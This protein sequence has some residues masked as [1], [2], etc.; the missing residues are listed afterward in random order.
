MGLRLVIPFWG[1]HK[2]GAVVVSAIS[3][4]A[5]LHQCVDVDN[6]T[7]QGISCIVV[8]IAGLST[9]TIACNETKWVKVDNEVMQLVAPNGAS[10]ACSQGEP[11]SA[12]RGLYVRRHHNSTAAAT[13]AAG[14]FIVWST[15][16]PHY[17]LNVDIRDTPTKKGADDGYTY[18]AVADFYIES[19]AANAYNTKV[20]TLT[21]D[22]WYNSSG[23]WWE[24]K[25][26][27]TGPTTAPR[28]TTNYC[29]TGFGGA[30]TLNPGDE[31]SVAVRPYNGDAT[32]TVWADSFGDQI[33]LPSFRQCS[34]Q[35]VCPMVTVP[36]VK[37]TEWIRFVW[38]FQQV[39][40]DWDIVD[41]WVMTETMNPTKFLEGIKASVSKVNPVPTDV[42]ISLF[43]YEL[44]TSTEDV[45][46][47]RQTDMRD[48]V[49]R[50]RHLTILRQPGLVGAT[51]LTDADLVSRGILAKPQ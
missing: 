30:G 15:N 41:Q 19:N 38:R 10:S 14:A 7:A 32:T 43:R 33:G 51:T 22:S 3:T 6:Y 20:K 49:F 39:L 42:G 13:H 21:W 8:N 27:S 37:P 44:G 50:S 4:T 28:L 18:V 40:N 29:G 2:T 1:L 45:L 47:Y 31:G 26:L 23:K 11:I 9:G 24:T 34:G 5:D 36:I 17:N 25:I 35:C 48:L 12:N 46:P 16:A